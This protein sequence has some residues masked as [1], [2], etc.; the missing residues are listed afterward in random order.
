MLTPKLQARSRFSVNQHVFLAG[1]IF[2]VMA[3]TD[4]DQLEL[5]EA[6][7]ELGVH[8][9]TAYRWVRTGRLPASLVR[10]RYCVARRDLATVQAEL[11]TP[12]ARRPPGVRR[13]EAQQ[14][15]IYDALVGGDE[16]RARHIASQ[17]VAEGT[18]IIVLLQR[19]RRT[20]APAHR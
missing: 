6:A 12:A 8:Y 20:V 2:D 11:R 17:L 4:D 10:G 14:E 19:V 15:R 9:Q 16:P 3:V 13:L 1:A 18:K 7:D 5:Q